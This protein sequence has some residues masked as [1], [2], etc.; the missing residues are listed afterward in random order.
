[1]LPPVDR[2]GRRIR[3]TT[4]CL[5]VASAL[6]AC[7]CAFVRLHRQTREFDESTV[8]VGRVEAG[9]H[10]RGSVVVGAYARGP[11]ADGTPWR[12]AHQ[13][14][15]HEPGAYELIVPHG[16]YALF[17]F[18]DDN[19]N[20]RRDAGEDAAAHAG[21]RIVATQRTPLVIGLDM[22]LGDATAVPQPPVAASTDSTQIGALA[23][24]DAPEFAAEQGQ[25][26]Y[27]EPLD[28]FRERGGN[29]RFLSPFDATKTP[30]LFVHGA[31]GTPRDWRPLIAQ[32]DRTRFQPWL[33]FYPS[34][35]PVESMSHLLF[36]KLLN[37]QLRWPCSAVHV[38]AHSMG[39]LVVRRMLLDHGEQMPWVRHFVT[40]STPWAGEASADTGVEWAPAVVPSWRDMQ[41]DGPFLRS[42]FEK[43]LPAHVSYHLLFGHRGSPGLW[44]PNNDGTITL[45]SQ[46]RTAAQQEARLVFGYDEDHVSILASS[47]V[48]AQ[49]DVLLRSGD[50]DAEGRTHIHVALRAALGRELQG[51]PLL[52]LQPTDG[53]A[54]VTVTLSATAGGGRVGPLPKGRYEAGVWA[55]GFHATPSGTVVELAENGDT[56]V[57]FDLEPRGS[58]L[59]T[60]RTAAGPAGTFRTRPAPRLRAVTVRGEGVERRIEASGELRQAFPA[61]LAGE[62][63]A[64]SDGFAFPD[65]PPGDY[66]VTVEAEGH[67]PR[68]LRQTVA[69]GDANAF[70]AVAFDDG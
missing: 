55:P 56:H 20:G 52:V 23:D 32:L 59:G 37:L 50:A 67:A 41:P 11:A 17:A 4:R 68:V 40:I 46:L 33:F 38:V 29:I 26:G 1:M 61:L 5:A 19:G 43:H 13:T 15:L 64:W 6:A 49:L 39:G 7:A 10:E 25:R 53:G 36:W 69:L 65:L 21:G 42:L 51:L 14:R 24:L 27:W 30:V 47:Q 57:A 8:L 18:A 60:L 9:A 35:A 3:T 54:P 16:E 22:T 66:Q 12:L 44:R 31:T 28:F 70:V 2:C 48:A 63:C 45:A 62:A 34:G 58:L